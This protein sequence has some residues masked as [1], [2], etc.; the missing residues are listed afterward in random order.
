LTLATSS[1]EGDSFAASIGKLD[2][3]GVD[4]F[5]SADGTKCRPKAHKNGVVAHV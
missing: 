3:I 5:E 1:A 2:L 4:Q